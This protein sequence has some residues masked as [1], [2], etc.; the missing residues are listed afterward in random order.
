MSNSSAL[1]NHGTTGG[2]L[3]QLW[4]CRGCEASSSRRPWTSTQSTRRPFHVLVSLGLS[5]SG[6]YPL[7][8]LVAMPVLPSSH[9][10]VL[11]AVLGC[12]EMWNCS[13]QHS[14]LEVESEDWQSGWVG[15]VVPVSPGGPC[16][17]CTDPTNCTDL[18]DMGC[19]TNFA[20]GPG[21]LD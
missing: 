2:K 1:D 13:I 7:L 9:P 8:L 17:D 15:E 14:A 6:M 5:R 20:H 19:L 10:I 16:T 21:R 18:T 12:G 3:Q 4:L 11:A